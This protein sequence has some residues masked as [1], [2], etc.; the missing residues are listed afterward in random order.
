M[1]EK[2]EEEMEMMRA[3]VFRGNGVMEVADVPKP[4][5]QRPDEV[6]L[7]VRAASICGSD[8]HVLSIP[9]G[10]HADPGTIMGHELYG[11]IVEVGEQVT[12]WKA[13]DLVTV[14]P[15]V[16]C[17]TCACCKNGRE[18]LCED[19]L[20]FGQTMD[21][22]FAQ[23]CIARQEQLYAMPEGIPSYL[24]A[25]A[26]PLSCVMNGI[27][28]INPTPADHV[29]VYGMGP[30]GLTFVQV[31]KLYGVRNL[32]VCETSE[33]RLEMVAKIGTDLIIDPSTQNVEEVLREAWGDSVCDIVVDAVGAGAIASQA[34]DLLN[35]GGTLLLFGQNA[36]ATASIA[37]AKIVT[38]ELTIKGNY[39]TFHTFPTAVELLQNPKLEL[40][41]IVS[42]KLELEDIATGFDLLRAQK[43]SRVII[44]PN[45]MI[46][47]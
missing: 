46:D 10:Q 29:L 36:N 45:G 44:Y 21:G 13:G 30:I 32:A 12:F 39:C 31:L 14:D 35:P 27:N 3:A 15:I 19:I 17:K 18:N 9:P 28:K 40:E 24:A 41:R 4:K 11:E 34:I 20:A 23:Y 47:D 42:H 37:P 26:E 1:T 2:D 43:A 16:K 33:A 6:L 7:R 25:Q 8:L 5:I 38:K 22:G